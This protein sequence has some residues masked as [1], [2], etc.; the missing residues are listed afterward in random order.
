MHLSSSGEWATWEQDFD[1][2]DLIS[3]IKHGVSNI[4]LSINAQ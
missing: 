2:I 1:L 4:E 3:S